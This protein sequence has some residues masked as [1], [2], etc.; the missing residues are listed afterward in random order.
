MV[1]GFTALSEH[2]K[3]MRLT[4]VNQFY[5]PDFAPTAQLAASLAEHRAALGD[6][7]TVVAG[8]GGY[9]GAATDGS[10]DAKPNLRVRRVWTPQLG[11]ATLLRRALDYATFYLLAAWR[12]LALP[13]QDAIIALTTPPLIGWVALLHKL[14]HPRTRLILWN[15]DC[16]PE[17]VERSGA[18]RFSGIACRMMAAANG[19]LFRRLDHLVCLDDAMSNLLESRYFR[20]RG[21]VPVSII[22]NWEKASAFPIDAKR[23]PL[24]TETADLFDDRFVVLYAGN[25]GFGH[26]FDA[27]IE[28]AET[29]K[30]E[31]VTF[32]FV[33][34]G[35]QWE[36]M[37]NV[38]RERN[39]K[40]VVVAG[41]VSPQRLRSLMFASGCAL[42]TL[43]EEM[44]GVMSPSKLHA[45]LA[46]GL[47]IVYV[48]PRGSNVDEAIERF[49]CGVS[50]RSDDAPG[51]AAFIRTVTS[52]RVELAR[53]S[54]YAR[55]AFEQEYCDSRSLPRFDAAIDGRSVQRVPTAD[56]P[57]RRAA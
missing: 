12:C 8:P 55:R 27:V 50:L 51:L 3:Q 9:A 14:L 54:R 52:D 40:N 25:M 46:M 56:V 21:R 26:Q 28:A 17:V 2:S 47:P 49:G 20:D 43:R 4:V 18:V 5:A 37:R 7:V 41:Y 29:L 16:Y 10:R 35:S 23:E 45:N 38:K 44:L 1:G 42:I 48:G 31:P 39:L 33:G 53:L 22:P 6:E 15:M 32:V 11:K 19:V 24:D 13:R 36:V 30:D 34:G 57:S